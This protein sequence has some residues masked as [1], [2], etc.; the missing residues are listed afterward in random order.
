MIKR[1]DDGNRKKKD[2]IRFFSWFCE[3]KRSDGDVGGREGGVVSVGGKGG[4]TDGGS[5]RKYIII[6]LVQKKS[7]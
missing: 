3:D 1:V 5:Q 2:L 4:S 7:W 6:V